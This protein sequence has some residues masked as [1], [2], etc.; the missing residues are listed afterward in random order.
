GTVTVIIR[1]QVDVTPAIGVDIEIQQTPLA[2][3]AV[4]D[5]LANRDDPPDDVRPLNSRKCQRGFTAH[6]ERGYLTFF[7]GIQALAGLAISVVLCRRRNPDQHLAGT[8][9]RRGHVL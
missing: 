8:G 9:T 7:R 2:N 4:T 3:P 6:A 1:G 5:P